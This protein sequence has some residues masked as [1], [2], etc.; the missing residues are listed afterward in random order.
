MLYFNRILESFIH[1]SYL[2]LQSQN[3]VC[4]LLLLFFQQ[5]MD[6]I[7]LDTL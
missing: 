3:L 1:S 5:L 7:G 6:L 4:Q 2:S